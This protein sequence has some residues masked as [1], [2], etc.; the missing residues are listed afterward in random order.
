V[1][2]HVWSEEMVQ[3]IVN[4]YCHVFESSPRSV[5]QSDLSSYL[6]VVWAHH[7]D[8]I[9]TEVGCSIPEPVEPPLFIRSLEGIHPKCDLL[10]FRVF[11]RIL[12]VHDFNPLSSLD[13]DGESSGGDSK[14]SIPAMRI[15]RPW[16]TVHIFASGTGP[17][18]EL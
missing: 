1:P 18:G 9:P 4:S 16:P 10:H 15:L 7:P 14:R 12:E 17:S 13:D 6:V 8:L 3:S 2:A 5:D 11:I